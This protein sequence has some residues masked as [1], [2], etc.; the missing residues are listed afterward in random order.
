[1]SNGQYIKSLFDLHFAHQSVLYQLL[2]N[3]NLKQYKSAP[4]AC[5]THVLAGANTNSGRS[6]MALQLTRLNEV[7]GQH[8]LTRLRF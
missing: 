6:I 5:T 4:E 3:M 1:M 7:N 8:F 2:F